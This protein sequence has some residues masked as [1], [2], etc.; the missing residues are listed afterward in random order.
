MSGR[1]VAIDAIH[2]NPSIIY[3]GAASG[4]VWKTM[5]GGSQWEPIFDEQLSPFRPVIR[6]MTYPL[7]ENV[8]L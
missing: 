1:I 8:A 7:Q 2:S 6:K 3:L 4:G 5:N